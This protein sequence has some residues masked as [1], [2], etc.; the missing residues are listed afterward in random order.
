M[1]LL[2]VETSG[3]NGSV[4]IREDDN[5]PLV[6]N[7][8]AVKRHA[9]ELLPSIDELFSEAG[10]PPEGALDLIAI[11]IG[12]GSY[13][14]LRVGMACVK[15][16]A[17]ATGCAVVGIPSLDVMAQNALDES[18]GESFERVAVAVDAKR[19]Q[20]YCAIYELRDGRYDRLGEMEI[21]DADEFAARLESPCLLLGDGVK[22]YGDIFRKEGVNFAPEELWRAR[23]EVV[24][25]MGLH[26]WKEGRRDD[27]HTLAPIYMRRP[28][29]EEKRLKKL[30]GG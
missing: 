3:L 11:S 24:A 25:E 19:G 1:K 27:P 8:G 7:F 2:A 12:P 29:A 5:P 6:K 17:W 22:S 15:T 4:C 18:A 14:G 20:V 30:Q 28:E 26:A 21:I 10:W 13:T 16:L 9:R 23:A